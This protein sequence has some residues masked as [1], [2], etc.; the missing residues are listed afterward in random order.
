MLVS[1]NNYQKLLA[2]SGVV[3]IYFKECFSVSNIP[4]WLRAYWATAVEMLAATD[5]A[6]DIV[7]SEMYLAGRL[8][9]TTNH[10]FD[11]L[12]SLARCFS[13]RRPHCCASWSWYET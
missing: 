7:L 9:R 11:F 5:K 3:L 6:T 13:C 2:P 12:I 1:A 10:L 4:C 8:L